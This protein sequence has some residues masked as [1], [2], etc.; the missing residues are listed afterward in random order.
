MGAGAYVHLPEYDDLEAFLLYSEVSKQ[1]IKSVRKFIHEGAKEVMEVRRVDIK[2]KSVD[3]T[4]KT[5]KPHEAKD[6]KAR[7]ILS[8]KV[9]VIMRA[10]AVALKTPVIELYEEWGWDLY[11]KFEHAYD[12]LRIILAEPE[13]V[14]DKIDISKEHQEALKT[15][16]NK[17]IGIKKMKIRGDFSATCTSSDGVELIKEAMAMAKHQVYS[18]DWKIIFSYEAAPIYKVEVMTHKRQE[19][20]QKLEEAMNI[21]KNHLKDNKQ[22]FSVKMEPCV[23]KNEQDGDVHDLLEEHKQANMSSDE[24]HEDRIDTSEEEDAVDDSSDEETAKK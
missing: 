10:T 1:R 17:Y 21:I 2:S 14:F 13:L 19:G 11:D 24:D 16:I 4:R 7:Y 5:V 6:A 9:H 20:V 23:V 15:V 12:A 22:K 3:V 18:E 8:K